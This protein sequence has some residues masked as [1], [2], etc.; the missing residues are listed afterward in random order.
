MRYLKGNVWTFDVDDTLVLW[1]MPQHPD[2][3]E[4]KNGDY[5][6]SLVPHKKHIELIKQAKFRGHAVV[7]W[8]QGGEDWALAVVKALKLEEYVDVVMAKPMWYVDDLPVGAWLGESSR[9]YYKLED[10]NE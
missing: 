7:V 4:L 3:I 5:V 2:A 9:V 1:G 10:E 8:S 6:E